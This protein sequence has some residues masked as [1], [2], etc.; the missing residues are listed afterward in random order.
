MPHDRS[1]SV[2]DLRQ[3]TWVAQCA[4]VFRSP[5]PIS[6]SIRAL[7][8]VRDRTVSRPTQTG[9]ES[10]GLTLRRGITTL[11]TTTLLSA[12]YSPNVALLLVEALAESVQRGRAIASQ[13]LEDGLVVGKRQRCLDGD[14]PLDCLGDLV[15]RRRESLG[16]KNL[17]EN[18]CHRGPEPDACDTHAR[19][20]TRT[21]ATL[22][23]PHALGHSR[24]RRSTSA[25][26]TRL[27]YLF[28]G[29]RSDHAGTG[30]R[31]PT[32][33][34][35]IAARERAQGLGAGQRA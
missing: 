26:C 20:A 25:S 32:S 11:V 10:R 7:T 21:A 1:A 16:S 12:R 31:R 19:D 33:S 5:R 22:D 6:R 34:S 28:C 4:P 17:R 24:S 13:C 2:S 23:E 27:A 9:Y 30:A 18:T 8:Q 3:R 14:L 15:S 35:K 29:H